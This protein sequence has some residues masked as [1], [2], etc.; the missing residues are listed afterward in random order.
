MLHILLIIAMVIFVL[1]SLLFLGLV[2]FQIVLA[3]KLYKHSKN[4]MNQ[5][6]SQMGLFNQAPSFIDELNKK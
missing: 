3:R 6:K 5:T 2:I 4:L 1:A